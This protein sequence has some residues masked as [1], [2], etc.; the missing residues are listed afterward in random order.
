[1]ERR[2]YDVRHDVP[3]PAGE[4]GFLLIAPP[5]EALD[6]DIQHEIASTCRCWM[7]G[8]QAWWIAAPYLSTAC[9]ILDR[10]K[11]EPDPEPAWLRRVRP[12]LSAA[13]GLRLAAL[14]SLGSTTRNDADRALN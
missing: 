2:K 12:H 13:V 4:A 6:W 9:E 5:S 1:M 14:V 8:D 7:A 3:G 11:P 10:V